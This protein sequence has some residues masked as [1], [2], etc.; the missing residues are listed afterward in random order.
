MDAT[1]AISRER[2]YAGLTVSGIARRARV[3]H[4]T[5]YEHFT[6]R[7]DA[8]LSTYRYDRRAAYAIAERAYVT[9]TGDWPRALHAVLHTLLEWLAERPDHAHLGFVAF[10]ATG[11]DAHFVRRHSLRMFAT[12]LAPGYAQVANVPAIAGEAIA[13]AV[14]EMIAEEV[15]RGRA[16]RLGGLLPLVSYIALAPFVGAVEAA[17]VARERPR[18]P[19]PT[20]GSG[21]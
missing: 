9:D 12:L 20:A 8:F 19:A 3:S 16:E 6:D 21:V 1:A 15:V 4:K 14:F 13:G 11:A 18:Q 2:G 10:P 5:F 7:H 17:E